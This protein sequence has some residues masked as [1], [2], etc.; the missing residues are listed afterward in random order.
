MEAHPI[1]E[2]QVVA[3]LMMSLY[4]SDNHSEALN[5][6]NLKRLW[7]NRLCELKYLALGQFNEQKFPK[8]LSK[9]TRGNYNETTENELV[10]NLRTQAN[11]KYHSLIAMGV[12][13]LSSERTERIGADIGYATL[14]GFIGID[15]S[16]KR[17]LAELTPQAVE[18]LAACGDA[19]SCSLKIFNN[20]INFLNDKQLI[21]YDDTNT[22]S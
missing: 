11:N 10:G 21:E 13:A 3:K 12:C 4:N 22:E 8:V 6:P 19:I 2:R 15:S 17:M 7:I 16:S 14:N 9:I 18:L 5:D 20:A 1:D